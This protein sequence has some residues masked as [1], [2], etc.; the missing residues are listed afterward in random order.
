VPIYEY[1]CQK[2]SHPFEKLARSMA[3]D[4]KPECPSCGSKNTQRQMSVFAVSDG[5]S[6]SPPPM[7]HGCGNGPC[8]MNGD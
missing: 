2:C 4:S 8:P 7:C 3:D 1:T 5:Q 6:A